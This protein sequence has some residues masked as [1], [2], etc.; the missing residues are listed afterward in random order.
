MPVSWTQTKEPLPDRSF[1][2]QYVRYFDGYGLTVEITFTSGLWAVNVYDPSLLKYL[3]HQSGS[4]LSD[5]LH[6]AYKEV[7]GSIKAERTAAGVPLEFLSR[8][9]SD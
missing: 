7:R 2:Y 9:F 3:S 1:L 4:I 5:A 8:E 6:E